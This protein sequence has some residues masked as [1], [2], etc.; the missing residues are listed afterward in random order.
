MPRIFALSGGLLLAL[1]LPGCGQPA[2]PSQEELRGAISAAN[3]CFGAAA[4]AGDA[5]AAAACYSA[6]ATVMPPNA[7][8]VA[9]REAIQAFWASQFPNL[10]D[11]QLVTD[12]VASTGDGGAV[13]VGH[14][15]LLAKYGSTADE[16]KY[17]VLWTQENGAWKMRRDMWSSN[18]AAAPP[19][20]AEAPIAPAEAPATA[21]VDAAA[22]AQAP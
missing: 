11:A 20:A 16:L 2:G 6:D 10:S 5:A 12:E 19:P 22:P 3:G 15:S 21:P 18:R 1:L 17:V 9:G 8:P 13:E 14:A 4:K 7:A